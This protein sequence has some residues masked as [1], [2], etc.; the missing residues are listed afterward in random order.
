M[1][2]K[3]KDKKKGKGAEKTLAKTEKKLSN[4]LKKELQAMGEDDIE[5]I[6]AQIEKE[7]QKRLQVIEAVIDAPSRRVNF[8]FIAHPSKEQLIL[9]G[10]EYFN[11]KTTFVYNDLFFYNIANNKWTVVKAPA[12]PP[13][14]CGHQMVATAANKGQLWIFGGEY[15]SPTQSQFYHYRDLWVYHIGSKQWEKIA[16]PNGPSARSGHR[17]ILLKKQLIV[18]GGFHDN[19]RDYKYFNDVYSFNTETY[20]WMKLEA[21]GVPPAPRSGC[22]MVALNDGRV[23]IFG[24]YSKE[25]LKKDVDKG[26]VHTDAFLLAPDKND[27]TGTKFK[28]SQI[29]IGGINYS[30]RCS[31]SV[32]T[33]INNLSAYC[34]G[35]VFDVED[36]EENIAGN[37]F[38][39]FYQLDLEKLLWKNLTLSGNKEELSKTKRRKNKDTDDGDEDEGT[40]I[41]EI[42]EKVE[43]TTISDDGIFKV[44]V[45]PASTSAGS[46]STST[47]LTTKVFQPSPRI[48]CGLAIKHGIL[49]LYGGMFEDGD[50]QITF[51]DFYS[52]DLKKLDEW[53]T[54]IPNDTAVMEWLGSESEESNEEEDSEEE[55]ASDEM[56]TD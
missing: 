55:S 36:D 43:S 31:M 8:S 5:D 34:Y 33:S 23:L 38:N 26:H 2:K 12:G 25:K 49:Y 18:F 40:E 41:E 30:P 15:A 44:T 17:M 39:D 20:T 4:K 27:T 22:C 37:F 54:L 28:W 46:T 53:K 7:E 52:L 51:N 9:Y 13:P 21:V 1:G 14:R 47:E 50:K 42:E 16:A 6:V 56:E 24:G 29:K 11:G 19:L 48:N 45:G 35:G 32:T 10:G 3:I